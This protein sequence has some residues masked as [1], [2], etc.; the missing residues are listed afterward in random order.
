MKNKPTLKQIFVNIFTN[1]EIYVKLSFTVLLISLFVVL[2]IALNGYQ[3]FYST[4]Y[5]DDLKGANFQ[6]HTINVEQGD[7]FLIKFPSNECMLIDTGEKEY[8]N[9]VCEYISQFLHEENLTKID[10]LLLTHPDSDHIGGA[11]VIMNR[12]KVDKLLRPPIYSYSESMLPTAVMNFNVDNSQIYDEIIKYSYA[13]SIEMDFFSQGLTFDFNG[14]N[15]EFLSPKLEKYSDSNDYSAV[16]MISQENKKFLFMGD[17]EK[18]IENK[19]INE[20]GDSLKADVLKVGHHGSITSTSQQF[21]EKVMPSYA[22]IS[23]GGNSKFFPNSQ[24]IDRLE[25]SNAQVLSVAKLD[26]F[27]LSIKNNDITYKVAERPPNFPALIFLIVLF[28][29]LIVWKYPILKNKELIFT[30]KAQ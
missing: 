29:I 1:G 12:F 4:I 8:S 26:N 11:T 21:I 2:F 10:Y 19:L 23:S 3:Y 7:C 25:N 9:K 22:I 24:I 30:K 13:N 14:C 27:V 15:L 5:A 6:I 20:Y 17:A 18:E 16:V 28:L